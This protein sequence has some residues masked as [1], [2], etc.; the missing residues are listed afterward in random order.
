V[1]KSGDDVYAK[2]KNGNIICRNSPTACIKEAVHYIKNNSANFGEGGVVKILEG[3]YRITQPIRF[4]YGSLFIKIKGS[5]GTVL[6]PIGDINVFDFYVG[7]DGMS[8]RYVDI[9]DLSIIGDVNN[10][11]A[12]VFN[13]DVYDADG[14]L[15]YVALINIRNVVIHG[16][17]RAIYAK[18][19]WMAKFRDVEIQYSGVDVPV[20]YLDRSAT[21]T[22]HDVYLDRVYIEDI[23]STSSV[24]YAREPVFD[25]VLDNCY[26]ESYRQVPYLIYF[27]YWSPRNVVSKC[28]LDGASNYAIRAG[29]H[30]I[31][32]GNRITNSRG[33]IELGLHFNIATDNVIS[34]DDVGIRGSGGHSLI[35]ANNYLANMNTGIYLDW[36][37]YYSTVAGN[38]IRDVKQY[39]IYV[40]H[41]EQ[42][43]IANNQIHVEATTANT[44]IYIRDPGKDIVMGNTVRGN[45]SY[46]IAED[47][48]D[49][50]I[51]IG[52]VLEKPMNIAG[53][54]TIVRD[55]ITS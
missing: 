10:R 37:S 54:H 26:I 9:E 51:I 47:A 52:N 16:V 43:R 40:Y 30:N 24:I 7:Q 19:L 32:K 34:V 42:V 18:N 44:A 55:N 21:D 1:Y 27:E 20:I 49:Y 46:S 12:T 13:F 28:L 14:V 25:V 6:V 31:I 48:S 33:G 29:I 23:R 4:P 8:I 39:G 5:K 50:N 41:S 3:T 45:L 38:V 22:T 11:T 2:D 35:I 17:K 36:G 15:R 53:A